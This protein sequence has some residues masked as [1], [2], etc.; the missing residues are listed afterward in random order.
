VKACRP[1]RNGPGGTPN[2]GNIMLKLAAVCAALLSCL[3][4]APPSHAAVSQP[5][6]TVQLLSENGSGCPLGTTAVSAPNNTEF[7]VTYDSYIAYAGGGAAPGTW[8]K[9]CQLD[10]QVGIPSGWTFGIIAADYRGYAGLDTRARGMLETNYYFS[11]LPITTP[12]LH[13]L[14]GP[15]D[16][17]YEFTDQ[18]HIITWAPC[19]FNGT[20]NVNTSIRVYAGSNPSFQN[21]LTV[22]STDLHTQTIA[23]MNIYH[24]GFKQC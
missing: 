24:L 22:D 13:P 15:Q 1:A 12:L 4:F 2:E 8:R 10:V 23:N 19:H 3:A 5:S 11:G 16:G 20:L 17:D 6:I 14:S 18:A 7:T 9:N 21:Q